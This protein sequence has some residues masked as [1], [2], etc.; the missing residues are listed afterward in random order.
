MGEQV[1]YENV[2]KS[3]QIAEFRA[4]VSKYLVQDSARLTIEM[5]AREVTAEEQ[6][7]VMEAALAV[8]QRAYEVVTLAQIN[9]MK[10]AK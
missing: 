10:S 5:F 1:S 8:N 9:A 6:T 3:N 4:F 7:V 2:L